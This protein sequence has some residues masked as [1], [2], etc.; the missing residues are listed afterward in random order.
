MTP[1]TYTRESINDLQPRDVVLVGDVEYTIERN[2]R[3][4]MGLVLLATKSPTTSVR[5]KYSSLGGRVALKAPLV[6]DSPNTEMAVFK[7]ELTIWAGFRQNNIVPLL[8]VLHGED[9]NFLAAM[10]WHAGSLRDLIREKHQFSLSESLHI[11]KCMLS[12]L[13]YANEKDKVLHLDIKPENV[14][15]RRS[16]FGDMADSK[17]KGEVIKYVFM[18]SDWGIASV[19][20]ASLSSILERRPTA[21]LENTYNNMGTIH[22][23]APERFR[24]GTPSSTASDIYSLGMVF[25]ELLTG[26]LP[27]SQN[28]ILAYQ[29][30]EITSLVYYQSAQSKMCNCDIPIEYVRV[31]LSMI[32][33]EPEKRPISYHE[34][35]NTLITAG[36]KANN[37]FKRIFK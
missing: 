36:R 6:G 30:R 15:Y 20:S 31:I 10:D 24:T 2:I 4:G 19:K 34:L 21:S 8:D 9:G 5:I 25:Y 17:H 23:M 28:A 7:R 14:L 29:V 26:S 22:Y 3:G 11:I 27:I 18:V 16:S 33:P 37:L 1:I 35:Y 13:F 32:H 12:G